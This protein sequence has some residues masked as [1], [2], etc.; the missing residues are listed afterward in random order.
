[1]SVRAAGTPNPWLGIAILVVGLLTMLVVLRWITRRLRLHPEVSRKIA[2]V[3]LGLATLSF[4]WLFRSAWPVLLVCG[5]ACATL[6]SLRYVPALR[7]GVGGVVNGVDRS[8]FGDLY[9]PVAAAGLYLL[10]HGDRVLFSVPLLTLAFADA[11]AALVGVTYGQLAFSGGEGKKSLEGSIA[12]FIVAFFTTH[13]P[14]LLFTRTGRA[15]CLLIGLTFGVLVMLLEAIAWRGLDNLFIPFGGF[16]LLRVFL[17]LDARA[18]I[19]R[20]TLTLLLLALVFVMRKR[21]TLTDAAVLAGVLIGYIA[22]SVGGWPWL[23]PPLVLFLAYTLIWPRAAQLRERPHDMMA[24]F[25]VTGCGLLWLLLATALRL[26]ALYYAYTLS[27]AANLCFIGVTWWRDYRR[28]TSLWRGIAASAAAAWA[29][30][31]IPYV[32]VLAAMG[33]LSAHGAVHAVIAL[34]PLVLGGAALCLV[35]PR[36][37]RRAEQQF[38]WMRQALLS[39]AASAFGLLVLLGP[40][41]AALGMIPR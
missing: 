6:L 2:H 26:P 15:E 34:V 30:L 28:H 37:P 33:R 36:D 41:D 32:A 25:S 5:L 19:A 40:S 31:F 8:S 20:L 3:S 1:V 9:F 38:P 4:P 12:F 14:L 18:L 22:W 7:Q 17:T 29:A 10:S 23:I 13:V 24:V 11:V 27:F 21:R 39:L 35:I 16:L